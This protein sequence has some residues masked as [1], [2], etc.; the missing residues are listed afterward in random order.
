MRPGYELFSA[1]LFASWGGEGTASSSVSLG[2][3]NCVVDQPNEDS[4][5][6]INKLLPVELGE[7]IQFSATATAEAPAFPLDNNDAEAALGNYNNG[8]SAEFF[9]ADGVTP[10][11]VFLVTPEPGSLALVGL[12]LL[13]LLGCRLR[14]KR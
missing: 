12:G 11:A 1:A 6:G 3:Y 8:V 5:L 2:L 13:G 4:C 14:F 7:P 9:E 10:V